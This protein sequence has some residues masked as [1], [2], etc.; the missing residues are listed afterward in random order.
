VSRRHH[1]QTAKLIDALI[2]DGQLE[3]VDAADRAALVA[4]LAKALAV[5]KTADDL[6]GTW[7]GRFF[8]SHPQ[9]AEVFAEDR[10]LEQALAQWWHGVH[11]KPAQVA[12]EDRDPEIEAQLAAGPVPDPD[13]AA[14]YADWLIERGNPLG[15]LLACAGDPKARKR[16]L[17]TH[18]ASLLGP[19]AEYV[20]L[21]DFT[22]DGT[23]ISAIRVERTAP[24]E[25]EWGRVI[26]LA[27]DRPCAAFCR[28]LSVGPLPQSA[29]GQFEDL[30]AIVGAR[31]RPALRML[32]M[33]TSESRSAIDLATI[34]LGFPQLAV[35]T[36]SAGGSRSTAL[37][38]PTIEA[39]NLHLFS[40]NA[41]ERALVDAA[42]PRLRRLTLGA[43]H[44][45]TVGAPLGN[46]VHQPWFAQLEELDASGLLGP[47]AREI[48]VHAYGDRLAHLRLT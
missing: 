45:Q 15:E 1:T 6:S 24:Y 28:A 7:V 13:L 16:V 47:R 5:I 14:V 39:L 46:L 32:E 38:H 3:L 40:L 43:E 34:A 36:L 20:K 2:E 10:D 31:P 19:V 18:T 21:L 48:L 27:L 30:L 22:W 35:L 29:R 17:A 37:H 4:D 44:L 33:R 42:L 26:A 8:E 9:I 23:G 11:D 41:L 12:T 25:L